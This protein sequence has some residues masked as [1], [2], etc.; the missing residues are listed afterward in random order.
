MFS[1]D[2]NTLDVGDKEGTTFNYYLV[3]VDSTGKNYTATAYN[4]TARADTASPSADAITLALPAA[5]VNSGMTEFSG[6]PEPT[7]ALLLMFGVAGLALKRK[8]A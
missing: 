5:T 4:Y 7:S 2:A 6:V 8:R 3:L 1:T